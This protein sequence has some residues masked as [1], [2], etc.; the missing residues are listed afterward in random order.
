[1]VLFILSVLMN[2][3]RSQA[4]LTQMPEILSSC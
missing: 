1:M 4:E 2:F 3:S